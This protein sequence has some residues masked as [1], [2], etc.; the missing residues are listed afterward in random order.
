MCKENAEMTKNMSEEYKPKPTVAGIAFYGTLFI[1]I[2]AIG[3]SD[4]V[5]WL[6][7]L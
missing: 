6:K 4:V 2:I 1:A 7:S 3:Y 5:E